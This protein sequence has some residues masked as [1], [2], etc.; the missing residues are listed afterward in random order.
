[1]HM[2]PG[3]VPANDEQA[4]DVVALKSDHGDLT[5]RFVSDPNVREGVVSMTHGHPDENPGD[6]TSDDVAV[7]TL[8]AM[9]RVSGLEVRVS[10]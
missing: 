10:R 3:A 4:T 1:V 7:D 8:T 6:L 2:H 9:P 5:A